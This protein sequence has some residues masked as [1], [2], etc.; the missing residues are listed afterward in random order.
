MN[1]DLFTVILTNY[2]NEDY[3]EEALSSIFNQTYSD[4]QLIVTDDGSKEFDKHQLE[5]Y[6]TR[7]KK[8]NIKKVDIIVNKENIGTVKTLNNALKIVKGEYILF[9][10]SDDKLASNNVLEKY[11][12]YFKKTQCNIITSQWIIC[13]SNLKRIKNYVNPIK[14]KLY[15][16]NI[17]RQYDSMCVAN[18]YGAGSTCYRRCVFEKNGTIDEKYKVLEDWPFWL[19]LISNG[20]IMY[21]ANFDGLLHRIGGVSNTTSDFNSKKNFYYDILNLYKDDIMPSLFKISIY[22]R[23]KVLRSYD[24]FISE[25]SKYVDVSKYRKNFD[26]YVSINWKMKNR[27][28]LYKYSP[29]VLEKIIILFKYNIVVPIAVILSLLI[30]FIITNNYKFSS[31]IILVSSIFS[32][33]IVYCLVLI[34]YRLLN[35]LKKR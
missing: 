32:Y 23:L 4:I 5:S 31:D 30:D 9:F 27:W 18:Q 34:S 14:A 33:L 21:Y 17:H 25:Y 15:N 26:K 13:D 11:V 7:K 22:K 16:R 10:A 12:N 24:Q 1:K 19:K 35:A 3:I 2:N 6:I 29:H 28:R 8:K 20:E